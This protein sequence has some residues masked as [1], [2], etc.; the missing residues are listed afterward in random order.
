[1]ENKV[2]KEKS[3]IESFKNW[4]TPIK[5]KTEISANEA[6]LQARYNKIES[7]EERYNKFLDNTNKLIL[8]C[9][10]VSRYCCTVEMEKEL[11]DEYMDKFI[12][13]FANKG[14]S[15]I[16]MREVIP[17]LEKGYIFICWANFKTFNKVANHGS[18]VVAK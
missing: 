10:Q 2:N 11:L 7:K 4:I 12:S 9:C 14:Y 1:M 5:P 15:I 3:F 17:N 8:E 6:Y 13:Y 16:D 18:N